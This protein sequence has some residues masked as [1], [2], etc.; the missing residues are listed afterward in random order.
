[1][2]G[3]NPGLL[4][5]RQILYRLS[6]EGSPTWAEGLCGCQVQGGPNPMTDLLIRK[7]HLDETL[8]RT[9]CEDGGRDLGDVSTGGGLL[10]TA[11]A[12]GDLWN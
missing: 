3:L 5:C 7:G 4:Y 11:E 8:G 1:M 2:Q 9:A 10:A 6:Y 12:R